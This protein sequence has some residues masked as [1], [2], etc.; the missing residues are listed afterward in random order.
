MWTVLISGIFL[1]RL[2]LLKV[3]YGI[4][5]MCIK[6]NCMVCIKVSWRLG[7]E[8]GVAGGGDNVCRVEVEVQA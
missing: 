3:F 1:R 6:W 4:S 7:G 8:G 5:T 2:D